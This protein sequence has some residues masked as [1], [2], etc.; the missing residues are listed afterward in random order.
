MDKI[1]LPKKIKIA[2]FDIKIIDWNPLSAS[3]CRKYGEFSSVESVIRV[4]FSGSKINSI[5]TLL[6]E[7]N[8]AICWAYGMQDDDKEERIAGMFAT[9]WTQVYRDNPGLLAFIQEQLL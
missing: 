8:H 2:C 7:I 1:L 3:S 5:D 6:H 4:D 9:G